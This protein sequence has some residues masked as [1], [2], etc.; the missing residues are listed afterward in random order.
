MSKV[1]EYK[2][3]DVNE[4]E[5]SRFRGLVAERP[6][7]GLKSQFRKNAKRGSPSECQHQAENGVRQPKR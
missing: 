4:S 3:G 2:H 1:T 6:R 7:Q 5:L